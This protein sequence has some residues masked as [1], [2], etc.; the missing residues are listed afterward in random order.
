VEEV[1]EFLK[2]AREAK[3]TVDMAERLQQER[4]IP[5]SFWEHIPSTGGISHEEP[6][7]CLKVSTPKAAEFL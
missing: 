6:Y 2:K 7:L 5:A 3:A 4:A 1:Q